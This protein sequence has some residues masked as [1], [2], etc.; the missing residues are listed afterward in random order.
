MFERNIGGHTLQDH[1]TT[2]KIRISPFICVWIC[3]RSQFCW[4][5]IFQG[6]G[7]FRISTNL[8]VWEIKIA[9]EVFMEKFYK[10]KTLKN[11]CRLP[12]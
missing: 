10:D 6:L 9:L 11:T 2:G 1:K 7:Y 3:A 12:E 4:K 8:P 5:D